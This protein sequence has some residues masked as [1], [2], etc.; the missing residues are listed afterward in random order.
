MKRT[1]DI[2]VSMIALV[3]LMPFMALIG[4]T[5]VLTSRGPALYEQRRTG[6]NG[7]PFVI[8]KFRTM[9][10]QPNT[11]FKRC[12]GARDPRIVW[13]IGHLLRFTKLDEL[14]QF[15][16]VLEG[17]MS[18]SGERPYETGMDLR[19]ALT[20]PGYAGRYRAKPGLGLLKL[21]RRESIDQEVQRIAKKYGGHPATTPIAATSRPTRRIAMNT[22]VREAEAE[23]FRHLVFTPGWWA[24]LRQLRRL[25]NRAYDEVFHGVEGRRDQEAY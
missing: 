15:F 19:Y 16:N 24:A 11:P 25:R 21:L 1:F 9:K 8:L 10:W 20:V 12:T 5:V 13:G 2:T 14:P 23:C 4:L 3:V 18:I 22:T 17:T 7:Q 6:L